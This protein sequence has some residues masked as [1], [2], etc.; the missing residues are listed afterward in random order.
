[1][2]TELPRR[3]ALASKTRPLDAAQALAAKSARTISPVPRSGL[4]YPAARLSTRRAQI[5]RPAPP[6]FLCKLAHFL[7]CYTKVT[8]LPRRSGVGSN[9]RPQAL[10]A[11][12]GSENY[13]D[14]LA[15]YTKVTELHRSPSVATKSPDQRRGTP[16]LAVQAGTLARLLH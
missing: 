8:E 1:M 16:V 15:C 2:V 9:T 13:A 5:N 12:V 11:C 3:S 7:A 6:R 4:S 14:F 10:S